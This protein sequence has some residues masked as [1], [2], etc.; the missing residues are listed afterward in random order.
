MERERHTKK[1]HFDARA[2]TCPKSSLQQKKCVQV[3]VRVIVFSPPIK[4]I[5]II[6]HMSVAFQATP[7]HRSAWTL[8]LLQL[9]DVIE[10]ASSIGAC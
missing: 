5:S 9:D 6:I 3:C 7:G 2:K 10:L 8:R 1:I 4:V